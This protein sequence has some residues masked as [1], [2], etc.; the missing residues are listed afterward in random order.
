LSELAKAE[1]VEPAVRKLWRNLRAGCFCAGAVDVRFLFVGRRCDRQDLLCRNLCRK[2]AA[3]DKGKLG[4]AIRPLSVVLP[5]IPNEIVA[6]VPD[7]SSAYR[8]PRRVKTVPLPGAAVVSV[9]DE[10]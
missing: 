6:T 5:C 2:P 7:S 8:L 1:H 9:R 3:A 4:G 10:P